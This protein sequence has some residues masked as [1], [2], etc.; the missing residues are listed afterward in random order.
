MWENFHIDSGAILFFIGA[1]IVAVLIAI[2]EKKAK[3]YKYKNKKKKF[4]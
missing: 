4:K 2:G 1:F 3:E